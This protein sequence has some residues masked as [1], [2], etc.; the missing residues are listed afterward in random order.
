[1][2][3]DH[4]VTAAMV[5]VVMVVVVVAA[6]VEAAAAAVAAAVVMDIEEMEEKNMGH[7]SELSSGSSLKIFQVVAAGK[8]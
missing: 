4:A 5:V 3:E 8:I 1:M 6:E 2:R 7:L